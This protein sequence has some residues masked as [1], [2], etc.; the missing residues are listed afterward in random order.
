MHQFHSKVVGLQVPRL[1]DPCDGWK[2][3]P[4]LGGYAPRGD[5]YWNLR[6]HVR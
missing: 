3:S 2:Q 5:H 6:N 1:R 4:T